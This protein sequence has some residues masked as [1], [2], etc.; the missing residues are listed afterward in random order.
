MG[1]TPAD[2]TA[3]LG[4]AACQIVDRAIYQR[5][6][7][8]I[9]PEY[10]LQLRPEISLDVSI[11]DIANEIQAIPGVTL[12]HVY[13]LPGYQ[14]VSF[15]G[16]PGPDLLSDLRF[17]DLNATKADTN[18]EVNQVSGHI[19][20]ISENGTE[21]LTASQ[22]IPA[23]LKRTIL[24]LALANNTLIDTVEN[25]TTSIAT[26][27]ISTVA[28]MSASDFNVDIA[29]LDTGVSLDHPDLSVYKNVTFVGTTTG[30]DDNGHGSHVAG[31]ASCQG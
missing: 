9:L 30:D 10:I 27:P 1:Q 2:V 5:K 8:P 6:F 3:C 13:D 24:D 20:Q 11:N 15:R 7:I 25:V 18:A 12:I 21:I 14:A 26:T 17:V 4:S 22:A 31:A 19:A 16:N 28:N 23:G 29:I